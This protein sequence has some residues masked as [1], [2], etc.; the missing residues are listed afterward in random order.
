[1]GDDIKTPLQVELD[2]RD[3]TFQFHEFRV[4]GRVDK[5]KDDSVLV[6]FAAC[7]WALVHGA[8]SAELLFSLSG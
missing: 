1:M 8:G 5:A 4:V 3:G 2:E 6:C 7:P